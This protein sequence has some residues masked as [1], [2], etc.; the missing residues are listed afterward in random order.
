MHQP[1]GRL[2]DTNGVRQ[3]VPTPGGSGYAAVCSLDPSSS[4]ILFTHVDP[5][6]YAPDLWAFFPETQDAVKLVAA[7]GY[8]GGAFFSPDGQWTATA[9]T[10]RVTT[11]CSFFWASLSSPTRRIPRG[12]WA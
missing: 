6:N 12:S 2:L 5:A 7:K 11:T 10:A 1:R 4:N 3:E 8:D 9:Q